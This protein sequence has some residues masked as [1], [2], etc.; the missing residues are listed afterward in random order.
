MTSSPLSLLRRWLGSRILLMINAAA[1]VLLIGV[2]GREFIRN[3]AIDHEI[4][5]LQME[6]QALSDDV[7]SLEDYR[8]YLT[9]EAFLEQEAREKFGLQRPGETQLYVEEQPAQPVMAPPS[10]VGNMSTHLK[11]WGWYFFDPER[12]ALAAKKD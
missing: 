8:E 2:F 10:A 3:R 5:A 6:Q 1:L 7:V 12:Y 4:V 11:Q 9:T